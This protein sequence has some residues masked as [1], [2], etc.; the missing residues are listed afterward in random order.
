MMR[1]CA[2]TMMT[3]NFGTK[4]SEILLIDVDFFQKSMTYYGHPRG[5][6]L[7]EGL[8]R[9]GRSAHHKIFGGAIGRYGGED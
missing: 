6:P 7:L 9:K 1:Y 2:I 3:G 4:T 8:R 5:G